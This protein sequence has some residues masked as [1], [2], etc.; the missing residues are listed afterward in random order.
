MFF[1]FWLS[2][3]PEERFAAF[4]QT[5]AAALAPGGSA[6]LIDSAFDPS[7]T[8]KD[9]P[10]PGRDAGV[11]ARKLNDGR[12]FRIVKVFWEASVLAA[13]LDALG[14]SSRLAKS[15]SYFIFGEAAPREPAWRGGA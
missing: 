9:H 5:V 6:Y 14:W 1:S 15:A 7:S 11:V 4:W 8:A 2:L 10:V 3:E 13:R 12:E